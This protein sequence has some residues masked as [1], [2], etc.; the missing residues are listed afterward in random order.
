MILMFL[1]RFVFLDE[2]FMV[3]NGRK[4]WVYISFCMYI[5]HHG[6]DSFQKSMAMKSVFWMPY[7]VPPSIPCHCTSYVFQQMLIT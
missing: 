7:I 6:K 3:R 4:I 1:M 2:N 5:K